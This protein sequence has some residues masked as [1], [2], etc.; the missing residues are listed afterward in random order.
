[1]IRLEINNSKNKLKVIHIQ[2]LKQL[3]VYNN[4]DDD[5]NQENGNKFKPYKNTFR[6]V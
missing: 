5:G 2:E 1:M 4:V 6:I 3:A